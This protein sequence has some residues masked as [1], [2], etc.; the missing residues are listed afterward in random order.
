METDGMECVEQHLLFHK[1]LIDDSVDSQ[2]IDRYIALLKEAGPG[3]VMNDPVDESIR[4]AFSLVL[5]HEM[6]PWCINIVEFA[7]MYSAKKVR[8]AVDMIVAGKLIH[9]AWKILRMQSSVTL[10]KGEH[11]DP[12]FDEGW[13]MGFDVD[14][15]Y[16]PDKLYIPDVEFREAVRR[17]AARPVTMMEILGALEEGL[18]AAELYAARAQAREELKAEEAKRKFVNKAHNEFNEQDVE[19]TW[20]IIEKL[21]TGQIPI[22]DLY[23]NDVEANIGTIFS[24]LHLVRDGK[25]S[26]YQE[27]LP[28]GDIFVE[29]KTDWRDGIIEDSAE[30]ELVKRAVV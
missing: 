18:D 12:F 26:I 17:E 6:D 10:E 19:R 29:I 24:A 2:K 7:K 27:N 25:L 1:A 11:L 28:Y 22:R 5:E 21:G 30:Q 23:V 20:A 14:A 16:E 3:E 15:M 4:S 9:M 8:T 13:D